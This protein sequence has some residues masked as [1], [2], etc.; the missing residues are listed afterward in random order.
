MGDGARQRVDLVVVIG[1]GKAAQF[2]PEGIVS[3]AAIQSEV[4][5]LRLRGHLGSGG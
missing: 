4:A 1:V 5:G 3:A 2:V